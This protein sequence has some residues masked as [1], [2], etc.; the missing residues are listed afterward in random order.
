MNDALLK[1]VEFLFSLSAR[2]LSV[3]LSHKR[4]LVL[5]NGQEVGGQPL[6]RIPTSR[7]QKLNNF[8][9]IVHP[10]V[11]GSYLSFGHPFSVKV[12]LG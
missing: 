1:H 12:S 5:R 11:I 3:R 6:M 2:D 8:D 10:F 9:H 4:P 7:P